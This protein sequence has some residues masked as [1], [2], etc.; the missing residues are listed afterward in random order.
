[1]YGIDTRPP[2][3]LRKARLSHGRRTLSFSAPGDDWY[4]G[5]VDHYRLK[6][7]FRCNDTGGG[8]A[9]RACAPAPKPMSVKATA[10]AGE[11][12]TIKLPRDD[13]FTRVRI[14]AVDEAG[15]GGRTAK[16]GRRR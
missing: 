14:W 11:R 12:V 15:N 6:F 13:F 4:E 2:G 1:M 5:K 7:G 3:K 16:V 10:S 9:K 8:P